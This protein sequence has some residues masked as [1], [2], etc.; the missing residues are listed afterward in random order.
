M[1]G[2]AKVYNHLY[3][4]NQDPYVPLSYHIDI[5]LSKCN[6]IVSSKFSLWHHRLGHPSQNILKIIQQSVPYVHANS[7]FICDFYH[8]AKQ[9]KL[10]FPLSTIKYTS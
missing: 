8:F 6:N 4:M 3:I 10:S 5:S 2:I 7:D 1:I 9:T